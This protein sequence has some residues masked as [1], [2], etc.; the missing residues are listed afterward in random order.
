MDDRNLQDRLEAC[1]PDHDDLS[2]PDMREAAAAVAR[3]PDLARRFDLQQ[4]R[5]V[6]IAS[7][8]Q[9]VSAPAGLAD[10]LLARL[11]QADPA[12]AHDDDAIAGPLPL[13]AEFSV[14]EAVSAAETPAKVPAEQA[15]D[16]NVPAEQADYVTPA[17]APRRSRRAVLVG[18]LTA[19]AAVVLAVVV[20]G[21]LQD[22]GDEIALEAFQQQALSWKDALRSAQWKTQPSAESARLLKAYPPTGMVV[23]PGGYQVQQAKLFD[24]RSVSELVA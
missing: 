20:P 17:S 5:D 3:D 2:R 11:A 15:D 4:R 19:A 8:M 1:R 21:W 10:R 6:E 16:V 18:L 7:A 12:E 24:Q 23:A 9:Q 14:D 13:A 22:S